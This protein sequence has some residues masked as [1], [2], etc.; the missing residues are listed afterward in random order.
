VKIAEGFP[1]RILIV[2]DKEH[3]R[4]AL[5]ALVS[6]E[7]RLYQVSTAA[8]G[9]EALGILD[10][11]AVDVVLCDQVLTPEMSGT[12]VTGA[13]KEKHP[14]VRVVVFTGKDVPKDTK[15]EVLEAGALFFL[16]K[17]INEGELLHV[18]STINSIRRTEVLG[19]S[20]ETLARIA[21]SLQGTF[22]F[23]QLEQRIVAGAHE[24]GYDRARLYLFNEKRRI[25]AGKAAFGMPQGVF[26]GSAYEIPFHASP[27]IAAIFESDRPTVWTEQLIR[28]R[29][30][31]A[32]GEPWLTDMDLRGIAWID[33]PLVVGNRRIGTL[34]VDRYSQPGREHTRDDLQILGVFAGL[35]AQ[36]LNNAR[37]YRKEALAREQE[38]LA[39]ASLA[40]IL[41]EAPDAII[42]TDLHGFINQVSPS[43]ERVIGVPPGKLIGQPAAACYTDETGSSEIGKVIAR[44]LMDEVKSKG[45]VSNRPV[46][47]YGADRLPRPISI[48]ISLV[49]DE[50]GR[51]VGTL[52]FLKDLSPIEAQ[53]R[54]YRDLLEGFG[55]G[56]LLL[57][58]TG[59]IEFCNRKAER[60][61]RRARTELQGQRLLDMVPEGHRDELDSC[62]QAALREGAEKSLD[63]D[64]LRPDGVPVPVK[65]HLTPFR[66]EE[67][68]R[69]VAVAIYGAD[70]LT[71]LI[72]SGR[73]MVLGQMVAGVAHEINNPLNNILPAVRDLAGWLGRQQAL[74]DRSQT[75]LDIIERN[76]ERIQ[77]IVRQLREFAR[78]REF[79][80]E[81]LS[82]N[83]VVR[84]ALAF[85]ETRFRN[86]NIQL[87]LDLAPDLPEILGE[88]SR[89][90][91]VLINLLVNAE[92]AM[93]EQEEPKEIH[94]TAR[95]EPPDR[96][97]LLVADSGP[98]V[99]PEM[100]DILFD[101]FFT[102]KGP[103]KGTGLGLSIS[104]GIMDLHE[105]TI[106]LVDRPGA[107]GACFR[108]EMKQA[109]A[110]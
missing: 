102:T 100:R 55:Y 9:P 59:L 46:F 74:S 99:A 2:D 64:I 81:P 98:G 86:R 31:E 63:L 54:R 18:I 10:R 8:S 105:G 96:V 91:Q 32:S 37:L 90:Q 51:E 26:E 19:K 34:A 83:A 95:P 76:G 71:S 82:L 44:D 39:R 40:S 22:D 78:P 24:L 25:L 97:V 33:C 36:A 29:F 70:E 106:E 49:H 85:L 84:D 41:R 104:K 75:Y 103:S 13:I 65:M 16:N 94:V 53:V 60:L 92:E 50:Q 57:S 4:E 12:A 23:D 11:E 3:V 107:R 35:A 89:L 21:Y 88:P 110:A 38:A 77:R 72:Q 93:E 47:L 7:S 45:M 42:T 28:E 30:G 69:G 79:R 62:I 67:A 61:L 101:P 14:G 20:F 66:S 1:T 48:S 27:V 109:P 17:P 80:R 87:V 68:I 56:T 15:V 5:R 52:G 108:I 58:E 6:L 73:L 43:V